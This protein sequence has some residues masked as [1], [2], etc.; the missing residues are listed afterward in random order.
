MGAM[1][2]TLEPSGSLLI[3]R[4]RLIPVTGPAPDMPVDRPVDVL[5][6]DGVVTDIAPQIGRAPECDVVVVDDRVS[7]WHAMVVPGPDGL[8]VKDVSSRNGTFVRTLPRR[9]GRF[10][11]RWGSVLSRE[12]SIAGE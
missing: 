1:T 11:L 8:L 5:V 9:E 10:R 6:R 2:S 3:R 12:A 7:R 4:A